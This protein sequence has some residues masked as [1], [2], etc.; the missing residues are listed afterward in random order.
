MNIYRVPAHGGPL[1]QVTHFPE[2]VFLEEPRL[3]P[4]GR[5]LVY[6]RGRGGSS[7]WMLTIAPDDAPQ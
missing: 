3:S 6:N 5:H 7:L 1:Q 2:S 4:D